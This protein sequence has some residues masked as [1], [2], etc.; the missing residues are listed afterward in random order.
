MQSFNSKSGL[1]ALSF[2]S[3][4]ETQGTRN[5][6]MVNLV[7]HSSSLGPCFITAICGSKA[8]LTRSG[9]RQGPQEVLALNSVL[10]SLDIAALKEPL[11]HLPEPHTHR[12]TD[13]GGGTPCERQEGMVSSG[14][15]ASGWEDCQ[16]VGASSKVEPCP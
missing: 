4:H 15:E 6:E 1:E 10:V 2:Q 3:L 12:L 5:R 16:T 7:F 13:P 9:T 11:P 14:W 8:G